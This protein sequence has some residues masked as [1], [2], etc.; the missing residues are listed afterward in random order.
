MTSGSRSA[1]K[2]SW[3]AI[4]GLRSATNGWW[5]TTKGLWFL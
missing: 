1:R 2:Q 5:S 4:S 3:S